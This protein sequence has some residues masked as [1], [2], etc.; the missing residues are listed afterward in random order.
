MKCHFHFNKLLALIELELKTE[1]SNF[2]TRVITTMYSTHPIYLPIKRHANV[3]LSTIQ[4]LIAAD[5][6]LFSSSTRFLISNLSLPEYRSTSDSKLTPA[7]TCLRAALPAK[8][9]VKNQRT[10][11]TQSPRDNLADGSVPSRKVL[12]TLRSCLSVPTRFS[13]KVKSCSHCDFIRTT[14]PVT[15][16]NHPNP[17]PS[18]WFVHVSRKVSR[19]YHKTGDSN[20]LPVTT[21]FKNPLANPVSAPEKT[22]EDPTPMES[23]PKP[24]APKR[25]MEQSQSSDR[26]AVSFAIKGQ[27]SSFSYSE[28]RETLETLT[29]TRDAILGKASS[30]G[31]EMDTG[32]LRSEVI[33]PKTRPPKPGDSAWILSGRRRMQFQVPQEDD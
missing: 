33:Y 13:C 4:E 18:G 25:T 20:D 31:S 9:T 32:S 11:T 14:I 8:R 6:E 3:F 29:I 12:K 10:T 19:R 17:H 24:S 27:N 15:R 21:G 22:N 16:C 7:G 5:S 30:R 2:C 23:A 1:F 28:G 26:H